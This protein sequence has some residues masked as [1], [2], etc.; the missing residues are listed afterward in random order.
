[1]AGV[2]N[3]VVSISFDNSKFEANVKATITS[4]TSLDAAI[5]KIGTAN[6][7]GDLAKAAGKVDFKALSDSIDKINAKLAFPEGAKGLSDI[8]NASN[9]TQLTGVSSAIDKVK[10]KLGFDTKGITDIEGASNRVTLSG[11]SNAIDKVKQKLAGLGGSS[12]IS[13]IE[14]ASDRVTLNGLTRA[15]DGVTVH[16]GALQAAGLAAIATIVSQA[17]M[18]GAAIAKSLTIEPVT[19]GLSEYETKLNAVQT[20]LANTQAAGT[21][22]GDV[23]KALNELNEYADLTIYNFGQMAKNIGTFTAA[24][25]DLDTATA[26]IKGIANLAA[27]SGSNSQQASTAMYQLSQEIAAGRV[28]LMGWNSVV[29]A[30]MGGSVFQR[31]LV[32]TAQQ[33]GTLSGKTVEFQGKMKNA[34]IDG[35]SF[36]ESIMSKPG[37]QSWLTKEVLTGTLE[38]LT[39][40]MS[41]AELAAKGYSKAQIKAIQDQAKAAVEAATKVKT[42]SGLIDTAKESAGSGWAQTWELIFG[43]FNEARTTFTGLSEA[44]NGFIGDS[45][46]ARNALLKDW[47]SLGGRAELFEGLKNVF[48]AIGSVLKPIKEA[49]RDIFPATTGM[50]LYELTV[51]FR[52]FTETLKM[53][54]EKAEDLKRAFRGIFSVMDLGVTIVGKILGVILKLLGVAGQ[55][56]GGFLELA[57]NIGDFLTAA[58]Q[59]IIKGEGLTNVF[60]AITA[61]LALPIKL[62]QGLAKALASVFG[63]S[64]S[65]AGQGAAKSF[66]E[67]GASL[68][69]LA[70]LAD[71][72]SSAWNGLMSVFAALGD[73]LAPVIGGFR[74]FGNQV[75]N[76]LST[77]GFENVFDVIQTALIGGIFLTIKKALGEGF[78]VDFGGGF[79]EG[80]TDT[81]GILNKQLTVMQNNIKANTLLQIASAIAILAAGV[82]ALSL[83]DPNRLA[84]SMTA[85][86]VG[87]GQLVG[88]MA[89]LTKIGGV[90]SFLQMPFIAGSIV[91]LAA[92]MTLLA[93]P[94]LMLSQLSWEGIGKGLAAIG[95]AL[96]AISVGTKLLGPSLVLVGPALIPVAIGLNLLATAMMLFSTM[97][98]EGIGKGLVGIAAGLIA[99][100]VASAA[101]GPGMLVTGP[102]L[103]L[104]AVGLNILAGAVAIFGS[105]D[106]GNMAKGVLGITAAI[107]L[108]GVATSALPVTLALQA[109]GLILLGIALTGIAAAIAL[110]SG[111]SVGAMAKGILGLGAALVVLGLG[112]TAMSGTAL[113]VA[114]L[115]GAAVG[116][117][118]LVPVIGILGNMKWGTI[119]KGLLA[120]AATMGVIAVAGALAGP[121]FVILGLGMLALGVGIA[122]IGAGLYLVAKGLRLLSSEGQKGMT[123]LAIAVTAFLAIL[124][125]IAIDFVKGLVAILDGLAKVAPQI[126]VALAKILTVMIDMLIKL[127][128]KIGEFLV[129]LIQQLV[130]LINTQSA[131][132][133]A[134][135]WTLL[136][137]IML[138]I[139]THAQEIAVLGGNIV[140]N[141]LNGLASRAGAIVT[142]AGNLVI[143]VVRGIVSYQ[144]RLV[145]AGVQLITNFL[146]GIAN[147]VGKVVTAGANLATRLVSRIASFASRMVSTGA[148]FIVKMVSGIGSAGSRLVTAG[149]NA[150]TKF[151]RA[152]ARG[153]V[154]MIDEG[155]KAIIDFMNGVA[156]ALRDNQDELNAAGKNLSNAIMQGAIEGAISAAEGVIQAIL[157]PFKEAINRV[158]NAIKSKSPSKVFKGIG[159]AIMDGAVL[160]VQSGTP[161]LLASFDEL[162]N[163][164]IALGDTMMNNLAI[165]IESNVTA[166]AAANKKLGKIGKALR[167]GLATQRR[168]TSAANELGKYIGKDFAEGLSGTQE[169]I[170]KAFEGLTEKLDSSMSAARDV[171]KEQQ[172][173]LRD[174]FKA[175]KLDYSAIAK[176]Q[177]VVNANEALILSASNAKKNLSRIS[178]EQSAAILRD[179]GAV[180]AATKK[181]KDLESQLESAI[182]AKESA[183][184]SYTDQ[185]AAVPDI[186]ETSMNPLPIFLNDLKL[187]KEAVEKY[188]LTLEKLKNMGL[189]DTTYQ[190][191][192]SEGTGGQVFAEQLIAGGPAAVAEI[193]AL[194][195]SIK[196]SAEQLATSAAN[197]LNDAGIASI[198]GFIEGAKK[199]QLAAENTYKATVQGVLRKVTDELKIT[200]KSSDTF[201]ELG[202][203][204]IRGFRQGLNDK[205][206]RGKAIR[207]ISKLVDDLIDEV[208][209]KLSIRSPSRVF[210]EIGRY[211]SLG[212]ANGITSGATTV[213]SAVSDLGTAAIDTMQNTIGGLA[214]LVADEI[215]VNPVIAPILDISDVQ[216]KSDEIAELYRRATITP[217]ASY[218]QAATISKSRAAA[219]NVAAV[220]A[221]KTVQEIRF[222]QNNY[223]PN[224]LS[225][226]EI[227]RQTN[228]QL[229]LAKRSLA[230]VN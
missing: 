203:G 12:D 29:N 192:L 181:L 216:R 69:P 1:M 100:G 40:D 188:R 171:I 67:L 64:N 115:I 68:G 218:S 214:S 72:V 27:L 9:K 58:S 127:T 17:T 169:D 229:A 189:D 167:D 158:K 132:L 109:A 202:V 170:D 16:F 50:R 39:G 92:A 3:R 97:S 131:P 74:D 183:I 230:L 165:G 136:R 47:K 145:T 42:L 44:L 185:F 174:L 226:V 11:I 15:I 134:A 210:E 197:N 106:L 137:N 224:A 57:G 124:P 34:V 86:A 101:M 46:D 119:G 213:T 228:N 204:A 164:L 159:K 149:T 8:E 168:S 32:Q 111:L 227:Y 140:I 76:A 196:T 148:D 5:R 144:S 212:M 223:S 157:A 23:T 33:M 53:G 30:G 37:E 20:I 139:S 121:A 108:L 129:V 172:G 205:N 104:V 38:Q 87:L 24:G 80:L 19:T 70:G 195:S 35:K 133:I 59:A 78:G 36:R 208:R 180:E 173:K 186:D 128:P 22:L 45:A 117:N 71:I 143:S 215:D 2:D 66:D 82:L 14:G 142:A 98:W 114:A 175:K 146:R 190:K 60:D 220:D 88:A 89:L 95:G 84:S 41:D 103:I 13:A 25:V 52:N 91:L 85:T 81:F 110:M 102:G 219:D 48:E 21:N 31:A 105:M 55:G 182:S 120:V 56:S 93:I 153:L 187:R 6:G 54:P 94:I 161:G 166:E 61:V 154:K 123:N 163:P 107:L 125:K 116:L 217:T 155:E 194:D 28:S 130:M 135:G 225:D 63:G 96:L 176:A 141:F 177:A 118:M 75:A 178:A 43:N 122:G 156:N 201:K 18:A 207:A 51:Q 209:T 221:A 126:A 83:I 112:L 151:V 211:T 7:L 10:Q 138:G 191:L 79:M 147:N 162:T 49:F 113:G 206:E 200:D 184:K 90:G 62:L 222:E 99:V 179:W 199:G 198:Q 150:A 4:L 26:S 152:V 65:S 193:N 77:G 160:G 73:L